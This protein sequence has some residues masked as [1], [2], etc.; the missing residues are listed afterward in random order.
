MKQIKFIFT[1][2]YSIYTVAVYGQYGY[3]VNGK[4]IVLTEASDED[5][6]MLTQNSNAAKLR[7]QAKEIY[8]N[9]FLIKEGN[10]TRNNCNDYV[11][12]IYKTD[13]CDSIMI[14]P[15]II[16]SCKND[17]LNGIL[18]KY[19]N[20]LSVEKNIDNRHRLHVNTNKSETVLAL[21]NQLEAIDGVEWCEPGILAKI[22]F[23]GDTNPLF[24][25]QY[26]LKNT[27]QNGGTSGIDINVEP[28]WGLAEGNSNI[29]V[30]VIDEGVERNHEDMSGCVLEG[31]T[32][33]NSTGFGEPQNAFGN[34]NGCKGHGTA[35][36]GIIAAQNN[37]IGI[38]GIASGVNILPVNIAP[39]YAG[40]GS[41]GF[42]ESVQ[43]AEAID[44]AAARADVLSCSWGTSTSNNISSNITTSITQ[45]RMQGRNGKGCIVVFSSGNN[46]PNIN[47]VSFPGNLDGVITVGA[48]NKNG[49]IWN[50]SQR[51]SSMDL[52]APSGNVNLG[53]DITTTDRMGNLGYDN[54][55]YTSLFGGTSAACPQVAGVA[56]LMLSAN[57]QLTENQVRTILQ[58]TARDLG[59]R[60]WDTTYGYGLVDAYSAVKNAIGPT[61]IIGP[62][63]VSTKATYTVNGLTNDTYVTWSQIGNSYT[64]ADYRPSLTANQPQ[65]N[66]VTV[67]NYNKKPF[68]VILQA[69]IHS[70]NNLFKPYTIQMPIT[71]DGPLNGIYQ[72]VKL[73]GTK[74]FT[75]PLMV[76]EPGYEDEECENYASPASDVFVWSNN[77]VG[78]NVSY[79]SP[80]GSGYC[81][82]SDG[83]IRFEMPNLSQGQVMTFTVSGGGLSSSYQ[84]R[85]ASS[86]S[87]LYGALSINPHGDNKYII[88][89]N[90][91][92]STSLKKTEKTIMATESPN[93]WTLEIYDVIGGNKVIQT[94]VT[95]NSFIFDTS[96]LRSG[97]YA[98]RAR[99]NGQTYSGKLT[100]K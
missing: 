74:G 5:V 33:G 24:S 18:Q 26:Y 90:D 57:P 83:M 28:A 27:G 60:G 56:A 19:N 62:S 10:T 58:E 36:A 48:I 78:R 92:E 9:G 16:L 31:Y 42:A 51:G 95:G 40:T 14:M 12:K 88:S 38:H 44:W 47:D 50:Y 71:G 49:N 6:F 55:N 4:R 34:T 67:N 76:V 82:V 81:N 7:P 32:V 41:S 97:M 84:F 3:T 63:I 72:E 73:D 54:G 91:V 87:S 29:T 89:I 30:A 64:E 21:V 96:T 20:M 1:I 52:V 17:V 61:Q 98:V 43:I 99:Y 70:Y 85:F 75:T 37:N 86:G 53:G 35:C 65:A 79:T 46:H 25:Q 15:Q 11:S 23:M 39:N 93:E 2:L 94:N 68:S 66:A 8:K 45:A 13:E 59:T 69:T 80:Q 77:F 22:I 100:V